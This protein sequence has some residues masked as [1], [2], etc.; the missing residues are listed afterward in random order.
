LLNWIGASTSGA[1]PP[2]L[3]E[4]IER[5]VTEKV[6]KTSVV[7]PIDE[8][9]IDEDFCFATAHVIRLSHATF[10]D[11][12]QV[13]A[14]TAA[15]EEAQSFRAE[16]HKK[17]LGKAGMR[18]ALTAE[19]LRAQ[20]IA[21]ERAT[22]YMTL[23]QF[24]G[25]PAMTFLLVSHAAPTGSRPYRTMDCLSY[26][27]EIVQRAKR[28]AEP[29]YE[30]QM[31]AADRDQLEQSGGWM[32]LSSLAQG[33]ACEYEEKLIE[34]LLVYGRACYQLD[35]T[36]KLLQIMTALEMFALRNENEPIQAALADR[37][38]FAITDNPDV[39]QRIAGNLRTT[40]GLRAR[41]EINA[42]FGR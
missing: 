37:L 13:A 41:H 24:Y 26:G 15:P 34:S 19:P 20:E 42:Q 36:D 28:V 29:L 2:A 39:R 8:L 38:A 27:G 5:T 31:T 4:I 11:I 35:P 14:S 33:T 25:A 12:L 40:Y 3:S 16:L 7:I 9:H 17:W 30:L 1:S 32:I 6:K 21:F 10:E 23:L 22:D 18:F